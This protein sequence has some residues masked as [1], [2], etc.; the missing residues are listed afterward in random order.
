MKIV[1]QPSFGT[2][3]FTLVEILIATTIL[4]LVVGFSV[5]AIDGVVRRNEARKPIAELAGQAR[6]LRLRAIQMQRPYQLAFDA[7]GWWAAP[8]HNPYE[9]TEEFEQLLQEI[10][11]GSRA[12]EMSDAAERRFGSAGE[13]AAADPDQ[14]FLVRVEWPED[15]EVSVRFWGQSEWDPL[16]GAIFHRWVFQPSGLCRPLMVKFERDDAF[17]EARFNALSAEIESEQSWVE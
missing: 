5:P 3:G 4:I 14:E 6:A 15:F 16:D 10:E 12:R 13:Q 1:R 2:G 7:D 9:E 17:F 8:Y 11:S